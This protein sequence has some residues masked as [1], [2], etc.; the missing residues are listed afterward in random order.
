[1]LTPLLLLTAAAPLQTGGEAPRARVL[2]LLERGRAPL[3]YELE[4]RVTT[5]VRP[6][7]RPTPKKMDAE[8]GELLVNMRGADVYRFA[9]LRDVLSAGP[10]AREE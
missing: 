7:M 6:W 8:T 4:L 5:L 1:M 3:A 10:A 9:P 2:E